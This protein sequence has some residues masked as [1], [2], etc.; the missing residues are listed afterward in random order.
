MRRL[1]VLV[2]LSLLALP[3]CDK[4]QEPSDADDNF[5]HTLVLTVG[6]ERYPA[7]I[8]ENTILV[9]VPENVSLKDATVELKYTSSA[10]LIPKPETITNWDEELVFRVTSYKGATREYSYRVARSSVA[11]EGTVV[12][13]SNEE[14]LRFAELKPTIVKGNLV[15]GS[16]ALGAEQVTDVKALACLKEVNGVIDIR[17][18]FACGD[19]LGLE[20]ITH[21]GGLRVKSRP[22]TLRAVPLALV[23]MPLLESVTGAIEIEDKTVKHIQF[24]KLEKVEIGISM[25]V[26]AIES[27][28]FP[29]LTAVN[30]DFKVQAFDEDK[31]VKPQITAIEIPMLAE[32][33]GVLLIGNISSLESLKLNALTRA[34]SLQLVE[35]SPVLKTLELVKLASVDNDLRIEGIREVN[36][37]GIKGKALN[38][39]LERI[40]GLDKLAK[41]G[42]DLVVRYFLA[43]S[44]FPAFPALTSVGG[45]E[46]TDLEKVSEFDF[47]R[48]D[49]V[50][51]RGS[52]A[53]LTINAKTITS[54]KT[55][56]DL[57]NVN[58][59]LMTLPKN[60]TINFSTVSSLE[61]WCK[62]SV[63]LG[64]Q[65]TFSA[66]RKV[67]GNL[68][69]DC[70]MSL[71]D[72]LALEEVGGYFYYAS[73]Y[74]K[75]EVDNLTFPALKSV[76]G[77]LYLNLNMMK[78]VKQVRFDV[79]TSVCSAPNPSY[80]YPTKNARDPEGSLQVN[81]NKYSLNLPALERVGGEGLVV[82]SC[83]ELKLPNLLEIDGFLCLKYGKLTADKLEMP[84]LQRLSRLIFTDV[85]EFTDFS[86]FA[87][88]IDDGQ[89]TKDNWSVSGRT[90][91][92][93]NKEYNAPTYD[94]MKAGRYTRVN[95]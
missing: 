88:F 28:E 20:N 62:G 24:D 46:V 81:A 83:D 64:E 2:L 76:G 63:G 12:L 60:L 8:S 4:R 87:K 69:F 37:W 18:S 53:K 22:G 71:F 19:L 34:L 73:R 23:T 3:S 68:F 52:T 27:I 82:K 43:L 92:P 35:L 36:N 80:K 15:I 84:K 10:R 56:D 29:A 16:D 95:P 75:Q 26:P 54:L 72:L 44:S 65:N 9:T 1:V 49:F 79:L 86:M 66:L 5:I 39:K 41:V 42:G 25:N 59:K 6:G 94:D 55:K 31:K 14:V 7:S 91:Y 93:E 89:I 13:K 85:H 45:L 90:P 40:V 78:H 47:S 50:P 21:A 33:G 74:D 77:Q 11:P 17:S 30:G 58:V 61:F 57:S 67:K 48:L 38:E 32:V 70:G 51:S